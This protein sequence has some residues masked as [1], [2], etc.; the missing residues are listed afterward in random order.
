MVVGM[1]TSQT[2]A[3]EVKS[4]GT[5]A[6]NDAMSAASASI[7]RM[8]T[9]AIGAGTALAGA[10]A[11]GIMHAVGAAREWNGAIREL[12][13]VTDPRTAEEIGA[14]M[15]DLSNTI[16]L[17]TT[18]LVDIATQ[19]SRF[20]IE[21]TEA[22]S[23]FTET[24]AQ[25]AVATDI[26]VTEA[27]QA[28]A[29]LT[30]LTRTPIAEIQNLGSAIN[31]L[32][33]T[34]ATSAG[35]IVDNMLRSS[36]ALSQLGV[37][38]PEIAG[39]AASMNAVSESADRAGTRLR[40]LA[41]SLQDPTRV[42]RL[43][44]AFRD[45]G[46]TIE[47]VTGSVERARGA[48]E[49]ERR[50]LVELETQLQRTD[51]EL[52]GLGDAHD[53]LGDSIEENRIKIEEIRLEAARAGRELT[54]E[55]KAQVEELRLSNRELRL[56][57]MKTEREMDDLRE[58]REDQKQSVEEQESAVESATATLE[59]ETEAAVERF[60]EM[61]DENPTEAIL[62]L[63][64]RMNE[65][66]AAADAMADSMDSRAIQVLQALGSN[67]DDV[68]ENLENSD[69][70]YEEATSLSRE[71]GIEASST[72]S[73]IQLLENRVFGAT[74][75]IGNE[76]MPT[77]KQ[78][79]TGLQPLA[80]SF[81][82]W[83]RAGGS[84][85]AALAL[86]T[87]VVGGL[88]VAVGALSTPI[89]AIGAALAAL[90]AAWH[91]NWLG[92]RD[93]TADILAE[94]RGEWNQHGAGLLT[95][96]RETVAA[97]RGYIQTG[98]NAVAAVWRVW[99]PTIRR[100]VGPLVKW[101]RLTFD[102]GMDVLVNVIE[103]ALNLIQG[104][105]GE[106]WENVK[107]IG[108]S[109]INWVKGTFRIGFVGALRILGSVVKSTV[110]SALAIGDWIK[111]GILGL[112]DWL[113]GPALNWV[114]NAVRDLGRAVGNAFADAINNTIP[115]RVSFRIPSVDTKF[116]RIGGDTIALNL[117][118]NPVQLAEGGIVTRPTLAVAGEAGPEA[119]V[120]LDK[121]DDLGGPR[122]AEVNVYADDR[123]GGREAG[124]AFLTELR[125]VGLRP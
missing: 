88:G 3:V 38:A 75:R 39:L 23:N 43:V 58:T 117:P 50:E 25:M 44:Q 104:D 80:G 86:L 74:R 40:R 71:F 4:R 5:A 17:A 100:I 45:Y 9:A 93:I 101:L 115:N 102:E 91:N 107:A 81:R 77:V 112:T 105:W 11:G 41:Q 59:Q 99:G 82:D 6:F 118:N 92:I 31:T 21:G 1:G 70:A 90:A 63:A 42:E 10:A 22:V 120:P 2:I 30:Q 7:G 55:E 108:S 47:G 62:L 34:T 76:F 18:E 56:E 32:G 12:T 83:A 121:L 51:A 110:T 65:G 28:F 48:L 125:S 57:Q 97:I 73:Q 33:Q 15:A 36:A 122:I 66:G 114:V 68:R 49:S 106:A 109:F 37:T 46:V 35:E 119:V 72:G 16:P 52:R 54:E 95:E 84:A 103:L 87:G 8:R 78:A 123:R 53:E 89:L 67:L 27:G 26:S 111:V 24:V 98:L 96:V 79:I 85:S 113:T 116:G 20:G 29:K 94:I 64:E 61:V 19:A 69:D 124:R 14:A 13:K 60:R